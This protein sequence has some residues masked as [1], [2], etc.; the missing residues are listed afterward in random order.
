MF[1]FPL[2]DPSPL[3][4]LASQ[5]AACGDA[6]Q[7]RAPFGALWGSLGVL[8]GWTGVFCGSFGVLLGSSGA[9]SGCLG[10]VWGLFV[11]LWNSF[12]VLRGSFEVLWGLVGLLWL[13]C[14]GA[15][16]GLL[17][18]F[19]VIQNRCSHTLTYGKM[20]M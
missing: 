20:Y 2:T 16:V 10:V 18:S 19:N 17:W 5:F 9:L 4:R 15:R 6:Q 11:M 3:A 14:S 1:S 13:L 12:G 7:L 8:W